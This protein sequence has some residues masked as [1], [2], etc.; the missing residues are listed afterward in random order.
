MHYEYKLKPIGHGSGVQQ[1]GYLNIVGNRIFLCDLPLEEVLKQWDG[2]FVEVH[3]W[4]P[5]P[6]PDWPIE[7]S[8]KP[9]VEALQKHGVKTLSSCEG[10][11]DEDHG[12]GRERYPIISFTGLLPECMWDIIIRY[13]WIVIDW[14]D[15]TRSLKI[16][17]E[18][19]DEEELKELQQSAMDLAKALA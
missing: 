2:Y 19:K 16:T 8:I 12:L 9:L 3:C 5:T 6:S 4:S 17:R 1:C 14:P 18:A 15:G 13:G 10:H 11:L 7:P